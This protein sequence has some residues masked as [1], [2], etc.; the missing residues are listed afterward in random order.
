MSDSREQKTKGGRELDRIVFF[1]D[2]IFA[3]AA[4]LLVLTIEAPEIPANLMAEELP[5]Q[6]LDLLPGVFGY[7]FSFLAILPY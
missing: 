5:S 1:S 2:A 6:L 3:I 7:V 4:T